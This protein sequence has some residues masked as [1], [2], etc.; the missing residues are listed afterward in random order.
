M[1]INRLDIGNIGSRERHGPRSAKAV[2]QIGLI[3][4]TD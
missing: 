4:L 1:M 3:L 2:H